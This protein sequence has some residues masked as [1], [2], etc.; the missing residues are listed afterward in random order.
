MAVFLHLSHP[1]RS[2]RAVPNPGRT[3]VRPGPVLKE[4]SPDLEVE[5]ER[6][7]PVERRLCVDVLAGLGIGIPAAESTGGIGGGERVD[8][9][10]P[11]ELNLI[12][13]VV[14]LELNADV[15]RV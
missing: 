2:R 5:A 8:C 6:N 13:H 14:E 12:E 9:A 10:E 1:T 15:A 11:V 7:A 4:E 3:T